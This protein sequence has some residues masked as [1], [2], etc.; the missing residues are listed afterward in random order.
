MIGSTACAKNSEEIKS[1][2]SFEASSSPEIV[3]KSE[4]EIVEAVF[5][6]W[7]PHFKK[8]EIINWAVDSMETAEEL[9]KKQFGEI[10]S[11][12][13]AIEKA[14]AVWAELDWAKEFPN[15]KR[16]IQNSMANMVS[17]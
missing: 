12:E 6:E 7:Y 17:G 13:D 3:S 10:T 16:L 4:R 9:S 5:V 15:E 1:S 11:E 2:E 14:K 8:D